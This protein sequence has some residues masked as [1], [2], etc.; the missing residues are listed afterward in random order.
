MGNHQ[1]DEDQDV[2]ETEDPRELAALVHGRSIAERLELDL[3]PRKRTV[4]EIF[5]IELPP[6]RA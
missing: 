1:N 2:D 6:R 5:G 3:P 4:A